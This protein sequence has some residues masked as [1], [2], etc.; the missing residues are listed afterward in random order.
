MK[1][2]DAYK[3]SAKR[4]ER[5]IEPQLAA[6]RSIGLTLCP[7]TPG[8]RVLD[9]GC[10][11]GTHLDLYQRD[12]AVT[13]GLDPSAAM[14]AE[15]EKKLGGQ[16]ELVCGSGAKLPWSAGS[17]DL[18]ILSMILH[19]LHPRVRWEVV[20]E[21]KRV[22][23]ADGHLLCIDFHP[24]PYRFLRGWLQRGFINLVELMAGF[25][26]YFNHRRFLAAGGLPELAA[27]HQL[28]VDNK[29][30]VGGGTLGVFLLGM[31]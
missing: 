8:M 16:A 5:I 25:V 3:R 23:A 11:T 14:L 22:L 6:L 21:A 15:A 30:I 20:A 29:K 12:G 2:K 26:H 13:F 27:Q 1:E 18:V 10:G 19:E 24:G 9:V 4:Y 28:S 17:F 7:A 31:G